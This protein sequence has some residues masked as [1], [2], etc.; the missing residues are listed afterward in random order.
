MGRKRMARFLCRNFTN[1][2]VKLDGNEFVE[3]NFVDVTFTYSGGGMMKLQG[4]EIG[5]GC[6]MNFLGPAENT[7]R[8]LQMMSD[9]RTGLS[10]FAITV[11][12]VRNKS[13]R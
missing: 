10:G 3:C 13:P 6:K 5:G 2:V 8:L 4:C 11:P 12:K 1:E 9:P 7:V